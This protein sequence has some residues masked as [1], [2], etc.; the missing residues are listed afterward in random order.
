MNEHLQARQFCTGHRKQV[1]ASSLCG[2]FHCTETSAPGEIERWVDE[3]DE[4][5]GQT[6]L[7]SRCG[8]DSVLGPAARFPLTPSSW[9]A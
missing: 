5:V 8:I 3:N 2:C 1:L 4:G 6:A 9:A 7:C